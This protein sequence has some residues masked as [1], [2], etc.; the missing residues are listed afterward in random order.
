VIEV[1][2]QATDELHDALLRLVPQLSPSAP[3]ITRDVLR[4]L[5]SS[6]A[7]RLLVARGEDRQIVGT[8]T[9]AIFPIPTGIRAWIEDVIVDEAVRRQGVGEALT[10]AALEIA[11]RE[12]ARTVDL[13]SRPSRESANRLYRQIGFEQRE[14]NVYR[15]SL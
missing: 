9:L 2:R 3:P 1:A 6:D 10:S 15:Y 14:T 8:L 11:R 12:G 13:T 4:S 7:V 5:V